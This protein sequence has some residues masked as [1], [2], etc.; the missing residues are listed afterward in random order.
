MET[1][2]PVLNTVCYSVTTKHV[3]ITAH[4]VGTWNFKGAYADFFIILA[5]ANPA[6]GIGAGC[7][8][9]QI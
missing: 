5:S 2:S 9:E 3:I 1:G 7:T 6:A 4:V 8:E